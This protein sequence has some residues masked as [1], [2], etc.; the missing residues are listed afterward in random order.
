MA[1][2]TDPI[3]LG[4]AMADRLLPGLAAAV[5][6]L[7]ALALGAA[8]AAAA[9]AER[10]HGAASEAV[11]V[12]VS[13]PAGKLA[14]GTPRIDAALRLVRAAPGVEEATPMQDG[15]LAELLRP[16]LGPAAE[17]LA[18]PLPA[19][20]EVRPHDE[21]WDPASLRA[22]L[23][24]AVPG[25]T[26]ETQ[27]RLVTRLRAL[28]RGVQALGAVAVLIATGIAACVVVMATRA[29]LAARRDA[30][31]ILHLL[32]ADDRQIA[33]RF[34]RRAAARVAAGAVLGTATGA[35]V[36][37]ALAAV[38]GPILPINPARVGF[39]LPLLPLAAAA[40]GWGTAQLAVRNWLRRLP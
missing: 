30:V 37:A 14:S 32:G 19:I 15:R 20:I 36:L 33:S 5:S 10:W 23:A 18:L 3:G 28:A 29:T 24:E 21:D 7:A 4:A 13:D 2:R 39:S 16:W 8:I 31:E 17:Q 35:A 11:T 38:A 1:R 9:L 26:V 25:T 34:A 27:G 22:Q 6:L 40:I 12:Q